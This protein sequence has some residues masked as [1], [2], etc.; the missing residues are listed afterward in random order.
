MFVWKNIV[1]FMLTLKVIS[2]FLKTSIVGSPFKNSLAKEFSVIM[3]CNTRH[4]KYQRGSGLLGLQTCLSSIYKH[5]HSPPVLVPNN[6][7]LRKRRQ[8]FVFICDK[9]TGHLDLQCDRRPTWHLVVSQSTLEVRA[10]E[11]LWASAVL[12][13][14][15][16]HYFLLVT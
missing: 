11:V 3:N 9:L 6:Q 4:D 2:M 1:K 14:P 7:V 8:K 10:A 12:L 13:F 16:K 5:P 15:W